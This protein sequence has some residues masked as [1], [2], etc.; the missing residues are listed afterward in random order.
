MELQSHHLV[1]AHKHDI[2]VGPTHQHVGVQ[3]R[4]VVTLHHQIRGVHVLHCVGQAHVLPVHHHV[5]EFHVI[6]VEACDIDVPVEG[7]A[8]RHAVNTR[9]PTTHAT[10][11]H[12]AHVDGR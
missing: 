3:V 12:D 10:V 4:E 9:C 7:E 6:G 2:L 1:G 5:E 11:L 8:E